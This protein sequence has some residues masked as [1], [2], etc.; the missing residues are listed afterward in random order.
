MPQDNHVGPEFRG[1]DFAA[2]VSDGVAG[3]SQSSTSGS[4]KWQSQ[5]GKPVGSRKAPLWQR[6][7]PILLVLAL[8]LVV[9][10]A[11][12]ALFHADG[13]QRQSQVGQCVEL[14]GTADAV[15]VTFV[16]CDRAELFSWV[17]A[18]VAGSTA[19]C[20][21]DDYDAVY[22]EYDEG[23]GESHEYSALCLVPNFVEQLCYE[24]LPENDVNGYAV[25]DC[26]SDDADFRVAAA[27][28]KMLESLCES[29]TLPW[30]YPEPARTFCLGEP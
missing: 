4:S 2:P 11:G 8:V 16:A 27:H 26:G 15:D 6:I 18:K 1:P 12:W 7:W 24:E 19:D 23:N 29:D 20:P 21:S 10:G 14:S 3:G 17:I 30:T 13:L 25:I 9:A 5:F 28:E 22:Y